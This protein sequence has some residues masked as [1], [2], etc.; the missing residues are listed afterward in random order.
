MKNCKLKDSFSDMLKSIRRGRHL[1]R[2]KD[3]SLTSDKLGIL[4]TWD[5]STTVRKNSVMPLDIKV[6]IEH[7]FSAA[8][9]RDANEV[10]IASGE[11][12]SA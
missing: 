10:Y 1:L 9:T 3:T 5:D 11:N 6:H 12:D 4:P 2:K 8:S 7:P